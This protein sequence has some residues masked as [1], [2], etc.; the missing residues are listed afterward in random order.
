MRKMTESNLKDAL[1]GESQAH[2]RYWTFSEKAAEEGYE[3][4]ARLFR[5]ASFSEQVHAGRH[6][7]AL[8]GVASTPENLAVA[9]GG[10][11]FEVDEL[12]PAYIGV[13][14]LQG[15]KAGHKSMLRAFEAEKV[16]QQ[17]YQ[18]A[19]QAVDLGRDPVVADMF[20]CSHCG[21]T[22]HGD[23]P[24]KCPLCGAPRSKFQKF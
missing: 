10:E 4:V 1:A 12:Y 20:V 19:K 17:L 15:E 13:A 23:A 18:S 5:A 2:V 11:T 8:S 21:F 14:D 22:M 16:H 9:L 7:R 24:D 6:L 3:N